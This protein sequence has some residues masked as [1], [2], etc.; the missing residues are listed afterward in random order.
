MME[1]QI[2]ILESI[3]SHVMQID[4]TLDKITFRYKLPD[5][6]GVLEHVQFSFLLNGD[7][8]VVREQQGRHITLTSDP[9][10]AAEMRALLNTLIKKLRQEA[11]PCFETYSYHLNTT[12]NLKDR[13]LESMKK[14][15]DVELTDAEIAS[16]I[17]DKLSS[18]FGRR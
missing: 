10:S 11:F 8:V 13:V 14:D 2:S 3:C 5:G 6:A 16:K 9:Y 12:F 17:R 7:D 18:K 15:N 4:S 1:K